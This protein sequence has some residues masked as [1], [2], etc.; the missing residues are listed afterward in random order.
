MD[1]ELLT[2]KFARYKI[3]KKKAKV[4]DGYFLLLNMDLELL[5]TKFARDKIKKKKKKKS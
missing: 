5:T 4:E 3:K 1:M 2:T